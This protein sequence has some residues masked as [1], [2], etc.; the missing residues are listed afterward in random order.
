[1]K[2]SVLLLSVC[3]MVAALG[4]FALFFRC[5]PWLDAKRLADAE[6]AWNFRV[7]SDWEAA[8][9]NHGTITRWRLGTVLITRFNLVSISSPC[10]VVSSLCWFP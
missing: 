4:M 8:V 6:I 3:Q 1:M 10:L 9:N 2:R 7:P 5:A